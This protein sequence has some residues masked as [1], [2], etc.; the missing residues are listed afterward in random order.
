M[1][2]HGPEAGGLLA[3][4]RRRAQAS[5]GRSSIRWPDLQPRQVA[6]LEELLG[7]LLE[8]YLD[9]EGILPDFSD[10]QAFESRVAPKVPMPIPLPQEAEAEAI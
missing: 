4:M 10:A 6:E 9:A 7:G 5:Q 1:Q 8:A 2:Q 3:A